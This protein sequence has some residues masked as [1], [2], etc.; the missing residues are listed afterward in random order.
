LTVAREGK[1]TAYN[2]DHE[3]PVQE[4][5]NKP[6]LNL[7]EFSPFQASKALLRVFTNVLNLY[8]SQQSIGE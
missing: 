7:K 6:S 3:T 1:D 8:R 2:L 5:N 4:L